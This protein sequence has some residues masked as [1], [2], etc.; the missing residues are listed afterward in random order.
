LLVCAQ[1]LSTR[2]RSRG[3]H[4]PVGARRKQTGNE[5]GSDAAILAPC[6]TRR[7]SR[8]ARPTNMGRTHGRT[9]YPRGRADRRRSEHGDRPSQRAQGGELE[10]HEIPRRRAR[11]HSSLDSLHGGCG[12]CLFLCRGRARRSHRRGANPAS[13]G[14][15]AA[16]KQKEARRDEL[17]QR[18]SK[19]SDY[20]EVI[21]VRLRHEK[22]Y[23]KPDM[24]R[25]PFGSSP[26]FKYEVKSVHDRGLRLCSQLSSCW[27]R[28]G[29][30]TL[31]KGADARGDQGVRRRPHSL[32]PHSAHRLESR[33]CLR[34]TEALHGL[35]LARAM[36]G[37]CPLR[38]PSR[39]GY[40]Y[41]IP[42]VKW[43]GEPSRRK[44]LRRKR[45]A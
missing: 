20:P 11:P 19:D 32:Q 34:L 9:R 17:R 7:P 30:A 36:P 16:L 43:K 4:R 18:L 2:S 25:L 13:K 40:L 33:P 29:K 3:T 44:R 21:V 27:I 8:R 10:H 41:E 42:D 28:R 23:P 35:R 5:V 38:T 15:V 12:L 26:W 37:G 24:R 31:T 39:T 45:S 22:T 6:F 14:P 1:H